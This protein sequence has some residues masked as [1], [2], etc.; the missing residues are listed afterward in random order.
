MEKEPS[1]SELNE[2]FGADGYESLDIEWEEVEEEN[3]GWVK[4]NYLLNTKTQFTKENIKEELGIK[5]V[6]NQ[7]P[8]FK[9]F[10][11]NFYQYEDSIGFSIGNNPHPPKAWNP[12]QVTYST[13]QGVIRKLELKGL[14]TFTKGK[15]SKDKEERLLSKATASKNF[16]QWIIDNIDEVF[17]DCETHV[18]LRVAGKKHL[19]LPYDQTIY[20]KRVDSIMKNYHKKLSQWGLQIDGVNQDNLHLFV[21][22]QAVKD[23][24]DAKGNYLF[25]HGG[26]WHG[27]WN[28]ISSNERLKRISFKGDGALIEEDY[29][30]SCSNALSLWESGQWL[31]KD[32]YEFVG[33]GV[34]KN[35]NADG[36]ENKMRDYVKKV[37][38]IAPNV[39]KGK[40]KAA[41]GSKFKKHKHQQFIVGLSERIIA[42]FKFLNPHIAHWIYK[43][44]LTGRKAMFI[45]SNL[46]LGVIDRF[47][48]ADIPVVSIYDSFIFPKKYKQEALEIIYD[49]KGFDWLKK[50]LAKDEQGA[51][52]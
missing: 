44:E 20:T 22:Y 26:R 6:T 51:I 4:I 24:K 33:F 13:I 36:V 32:P 46:V 17:I 23:Q 5:L 12:H 45:E 10:I 25:R 50:T 47:C 34:L 16:M 7:V 42:G 8:T 19:I 2:L 38:N 29:Q 39:G 18:R 9:L 30:A 52:K 41:V 3:E 14:I 49:T 40:L 15:A 27:P 1:I 11:C 21:N 28:S 31:D 48:K 37:I 35:F 43:S